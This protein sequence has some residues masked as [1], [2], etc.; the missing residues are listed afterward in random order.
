LSDNHYYKALALEKLGRN[1]EALEIFDGLITLGKKRISSSEVDFF[2]KF[3][4]RQTLDDRLSDA[5][6]LVGLG[7]LGKEM[8]KEAESMFSESVRL[9][10][11]HVWATKYLSKDLKK[12]T[13]KNYQGEKP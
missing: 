3:G 11:N 7:Y 4:E 6:Y 5:Y 1:K 13:K 9:N 12:W 10:I 2:A 8:K